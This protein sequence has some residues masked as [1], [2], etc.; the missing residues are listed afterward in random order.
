MHRGIARTEKSGLMGCPIVDSPLNAEKTLPQS[1][2][3]ANLRL[4]IC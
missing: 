4:S 2:T 1:L 3:Y